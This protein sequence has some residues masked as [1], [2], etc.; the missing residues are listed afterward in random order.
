MSSVL[1]IESAIRKLPKED[2]WRLA[3]WFDEVKADALGDK[4]QADAAS[5]RLDFL[6]DEADAARK[7]GTT[8]PWPANT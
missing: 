3:E 6:F 7:S 4:M 8:R 2:F 5:G 1:E